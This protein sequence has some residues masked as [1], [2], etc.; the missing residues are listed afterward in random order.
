MVESSVVWAE[1]CN[2]EGQVFLDIVDGIGNVKR[3]VV[4]SEVSC[5][6]G[7]EIC[8]FSQPCVGFGCVWWFSD[9]IRVDRCDYMF[10]FVGFHDPSGI[11]GFGSECHVF[12]V[13]MFVYSCHVADSVCGCARRRGI[14]ECTC[15]DCH[16]LENDEMR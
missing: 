2:W 3:D 10:D 7:N 11:V 12:V 16:V 1:V 13:G 14:S 9:G 6:S 5:E 4:I 15:M 8:P